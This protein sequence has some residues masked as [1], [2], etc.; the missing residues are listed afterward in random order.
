MFISDVRDE[1][2]VLNDAMTSENE[3]SQTGEQ[4]E[5]KVQIAIDKMKT[6]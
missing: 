3:I 4:N 2:N 5:L 1:E 6:N